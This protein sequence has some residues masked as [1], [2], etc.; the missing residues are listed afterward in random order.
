MFPVATLFVTL[1]KQVVCMFTALQK[2]I[3][4][5][6]KRQW[7]GGIYLSLYGNT[8]VVEVFCRRLKHTESSLPAVQDKIPKVSPAFFK[9]YDMIIH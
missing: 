5:Q 8:L 3:C 1:G 6:E 4:G 2:M 7:V 9:V